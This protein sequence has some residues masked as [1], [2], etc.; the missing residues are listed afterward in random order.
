MRRRPR[1]PPP[2]S[3]GSRRLQRWTRRTAKAP[4]LDDGGADCGR[5]SLWSRG[6][7]GVDLL[8]PGAFWNVHVPS[9]TGY[10]AGGAAEA[11]TTRAPHVE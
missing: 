4:G 3:R 1:R 6:R 8:P 7:E 11:G 5:L 10:S 2:Q 9:C